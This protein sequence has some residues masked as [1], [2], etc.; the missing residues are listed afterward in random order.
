M[1]FWNEVAAK[2]EEE[3]KEERNNF[4][5]ERFRKNFLKAVYTK[6]KK[7]K[8]EVYIAKVIE[9]EE[10]L[11]LPV[12]YDKDIICCPEP[13]DFIGAFNDS[14]GN[15]SKSQDIM[16]DMV[17]GK[18]KYGK[19]RFETIHLDHEPKD[20]IWFNSTRNGVNLRPGMLEEGDGQAYAPV[21]LG[22][23]LVHGVVLEQFNSKYAYR[24]FAVGT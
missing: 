15:L 8:D 21:T 20:G 3:E 22:D 19:A 4:L 14:I 1:E 10:K 5:H 13:L 9:G 16:R 23:L 6:Q 11:V 18:K 24:V 17:S 12:S 2:K 7:F